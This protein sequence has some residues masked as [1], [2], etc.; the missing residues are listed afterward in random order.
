MSIIC[1]IHQ[2]IADIRRMMRRVNKAYTQ[3]VPAPIPD[4][5]HATKRGLDSRCL[6]T[7]TV[8]ASNKAPSPE[9]PLGL[10]LD[11]SILRKF[12]VDM[13]FD[14]SQPRIPQNAM[15]EAAAIAAFEAEGLTPEFF[16]PLK[17]M[18]PMLAAAIDM[19]FNN[20]PFD[21]KLYITVHSTL[22]L[23]IDDCAQNF[24]VQ[25]VPELSTFVTS[26]GGDRA[27]AKFK[28][29]NIAHFFRLISEDTPR[30]FGPIATAA[31]VKASLDFLLACLIE[32][33]FPRGLACVPDTAS[34]FPHY[35]RLKSGS[36][37]A[38]AYFLFPE[39]LFPEKDCL[40]TYL[41]TVP[42]VT[43]I[44][45]MVNDILSFYKESVVGREENNFFMNSARIHNI[46]PVELLQET[47]A[48]QKKLAADISATL[49]KRPDL[50]KTFET[51]LKGYIMWHCCQKRYRLSEL[52]IELG[53]PAP[54]RRE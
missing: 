27:K 31:I 44:T 3:L 41:P 47:A 43:E 42:D 22:L 14:T 21:V 40:E 48:K 34:R 28:N 9:R 15:L 23:Y 30:Y 13:G 8:N 49:S 29:P 32:S 2:F 1:D 45:D 16:E 46:S 52:G 12:L 26:L 5:A 20:H 33:K 54:I 7:A 51:Y 25:T 38:Y 11:V 36:S 6:V 18:V 19:P 4:S 35:L 39:A 37:E 50:K 24:P 17:R 10:D 53:A